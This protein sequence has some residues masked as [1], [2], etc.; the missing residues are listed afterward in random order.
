MTVVKS[1]SFVPQ[2]SFEEILGRLG[3]KYLSFRSSGPHTEL[4]TENWAPRALLPLFSLAKALGR[5]EGFE[6]RPG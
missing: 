2:D 5:S 4:V 1:L 6:M 3:S